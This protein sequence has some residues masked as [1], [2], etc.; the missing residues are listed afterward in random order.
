MHAAQKG[1]PRR[2]PTAVMGQGELLHEGGEGSGVSQSPCT[3]TLGT[4][5]ALEAAAKGQAQDPT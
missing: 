3:H 1:V 5:L 4:P 2:A